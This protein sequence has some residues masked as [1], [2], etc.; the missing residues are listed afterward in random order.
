VVTVHTDLDDAAGV[1]NYTLDSDPGPV[2]HLAY[3]KFE[4]TSDETRTLL[5]KYWQM[6][7]GDPY[8]ESYV[9]K[10]ILQAPSWDRELSHALSGMKASYDAQADTEKH[11]VTLVIRLEKQ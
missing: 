1:A 9:N 7:P 4:N 10:F 2:Y 5:M 3:L 11:E 6:V 8:D